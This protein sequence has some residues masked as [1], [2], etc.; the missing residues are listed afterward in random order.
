MYLMANILDGQSCFDTVDVRRKGNGAA[1][2]DSQVIVPNSAFSCNGRVTGYLISLELVGDSGGYPS[3]QV[4]HPTNPTEYTRVDTEC[5]LTA[6]DISMMMDGNGDYYLGNVSCT[7]NNRIEFQSGDII[8]Y[9][10]G[11]TVRYRLWSINAE[12]YK[13]HHRRNA[14]SPLNTF[15][16]NHNDA[17]STD[18]QPLIQVMYGKINTLTFT[19]KFSSY[20]SEIDVNVFLFTNL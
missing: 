6:S 19:E 4:W 9:H 7:G 3:V 11:S 2:T 1:S 8:G 15:D 10:H 14:N 12:G 18:E 20:H 17:S 16:I 13:S 5:P